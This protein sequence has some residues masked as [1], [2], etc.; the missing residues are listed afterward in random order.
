PEVCVEIFQSFNSGDIARAE[1]LQAKLTPLAAAV[2]TRFGIG[3]LKAAMRLAGYQGGDV[4]APLEM[5]NDEQREEIE[6]LY[7]DV[8]EIAR[9][10]SA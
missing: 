4:R 6:R 9:S 2:T 3:G 5:P 1:T 7:R 8:I 10:T